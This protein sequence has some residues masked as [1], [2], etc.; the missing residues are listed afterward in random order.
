[1]C[2]FEKKAFGDNLEKL[3]AA[4]RK[5][6]EHSRKR[7]TVSTDAHAEFLA[8][9]KFGDRLAD[10]IARI[11]GS[12][13]FIISFLVAVGYQPRLAFGKLLQTI[14]DL[15]KIALVSAENM[16]T[17]QKP[18]G[19][20]QRSGLNRHIIRASMLPK[21]RRAA[22]FAKA[23]LG[24]LAGWIPGEIVA[25]LNLDLA[26]GAIGRSVIEP[27]LLATLRAMAKNHLAQRT[28]DLI[29]NRAAQAGARVNV[30][31]FIPQT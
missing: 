27:G 1:M 10:A 11:G 15:V 5:V 31:H 17:R 8:E 13:G 7:K 25:A 29:A 30:R 28:L 6:L 4:E 16:I 12:W 9:A 20:V 21:Q 23:A 3:G 24:L 26:I 14:P 19:L 18:A 22:G 2:D